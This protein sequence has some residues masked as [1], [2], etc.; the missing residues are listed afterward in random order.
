[1]NDT[2]DLWKRCGDAL[3]EQVSEATWRTWLQGLEPRGLRRRPAGAQRSELAGAGT[4]R[5]P[6]PRVD[7]G[8]GHRSGVA[9]EVKVRLDVGPMPSPTRCHSPR[10]STTSPPPPIPR[11]PRT[12]ATPGSGAPGSRRASSPRTATS[13][14]STSATPSTPSSSG[15]RTASPT[16]RPRPWRRCRPSPTTPCSS[17]ATPGWARPISCTP[18]A[19]TSGRTSPGRRVRYVSTETFLNEFVD[20]IRNNTTTAFKRRY[21]ECDVLLID[22]VQFM[23]N[24]E[25][26]QEEFFHTFNHLY[27]ASKPG[28]AHLGPRPQVH[29]HPRGPPP[30]PVPVRASSPTS[31]PPSSRPAWPSCRRSSNASPRRCPTRSWSSS[32]PTSP[33]TSAS[34]K[35]P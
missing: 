10:S 9:R 25:A 13:G 6:L 3:R 31:S 28:G 21:R 5:E 4:G 22:D 23:E 19:T 14:A 8:G 34:S 18:S 24:K 26:L 29:R 32:P 33:T 2:N 20:A 11:S 35:G 15:R 12:R 16:P 27:G 30:Q 1:M 17:T 7:R